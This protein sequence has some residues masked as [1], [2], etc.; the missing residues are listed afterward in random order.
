MPQSCATKLFASEEKNRRLNLKLVEILK[1]L[2]KNPEI[3]TFIVAM[4]PIIEL[5]GAIPIGVGLGMGHWSAMLI[6]IFG[7]LVPVP[8]IIIFIRRIF[9]WMRKKL[10]K[11]GG[12]VDRMEKKVENKKEFMY[13]WQLIGLVILVAIPLPGTGAWTGALIAALMDIRLK[14]AFPAIAL[15]VVIAGLLVTGITFGFTEIF[16]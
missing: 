12:L 16:V 5:R 14:A 2:T 3:I 1:N 10:P 15:G 4:V 11:L 13:K 9:M 6:S 7:N 8:F